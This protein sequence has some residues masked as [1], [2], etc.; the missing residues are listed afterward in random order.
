MQKPARVDKKRMKKVRSFCSHKNTTYNATK[1]AGNASAHTKLASDKK[2]AANEFVQ[3]IFAALMQHWICGVNCSQRTVRLL[4]ACQRLMLRQLRNSTHV[5]PNEESRT[6]AC[7]PNA[8]PATM[9]EQVSLRIGGRACSCGACKCA[10][11]AGT[12]AW[13][14]SKRSTDKLKNQT[15]TNKQRATQRNASH[16]SARLATCAQ[17]L[18]VISQVCSTQLPKGSQFDDW[19]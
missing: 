5:G 1:R 11:K 9:Q 2:Q 3:A 19:A 15:P 4:T 12:V 7:N 18:R 16:K 6:K 14:S 13:C 8:T 17:F 10:A